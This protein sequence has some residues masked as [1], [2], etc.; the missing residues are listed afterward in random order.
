MPASYAFGH[1]VSTEDVSSSGT[2]FYA[3]PNFWE[4]ALLHPMC[5]KC[6]VG[7]ETAHLDS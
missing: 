5:N 3:L 1:A 7:L 6:L 4:I 2:N